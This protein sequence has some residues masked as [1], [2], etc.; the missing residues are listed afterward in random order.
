[1]GEEVAGRRARGRRRG[2]GLAGLGGG[3]HGDRQRG[4]RAT[5]ARGS[6]TELAVIA[7]LMREGGVEGNRG[8]GISSRFESTTGGGRQRII[9]LTREAGASCQWKSSNQK[10]RNLMSVSSCKE[11]ITDPNHSAPPEHMKVDSDR[12][13]AGVL[14]YGANSFDF[15][16]KHEAGIYYRIM[17]N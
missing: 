17:T 13:F 11:F 9:G 15:S 6:S 14:F 5:L 1:V 7:C 10:P 3:G 2:L 4:C 12:K 16:P 8:L